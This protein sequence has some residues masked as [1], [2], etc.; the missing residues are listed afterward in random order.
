M[1]VSEVEPC[2]GLTSKSWEVETGHV[3]YIKHVLEF[4]MKV[5]RGHWDY[6]LVSE[7]SGNNYVNL[8]IINNYQAL[9]P[10]PE[11]ILSSKTKQNDVHLHS[12]NCW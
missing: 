1:S 8:M 12:G 5:H 3:R 10:K 2:L 4:Q 9:G 11:S 7:S 6:L